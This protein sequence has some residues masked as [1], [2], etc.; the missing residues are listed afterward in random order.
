MTNKDLIERARNADL[1]KYLL[2]RNEPLQKIGNRHQHKLHD[3]LVFVG[4]FYFWNSRAEYAIDYLTRHLNMDFREAI[5][6]KE[7]PPSQAYFNTLCN[8]PLLLKKIA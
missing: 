1:A 5:Q 8:S 7:N 3:S 6:E 2:M 4:C